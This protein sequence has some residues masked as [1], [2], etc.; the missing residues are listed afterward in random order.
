[1]PIVVGWWGADGGGEAT[2]DAMVAAGADRVSASLADACARVQEVALL[3][4][5]SRPTAEPASSTL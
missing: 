4:R 2:R 5:A 3:E 1:L